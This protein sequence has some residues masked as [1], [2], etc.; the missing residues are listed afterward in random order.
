MAPL[1]RLGGLGGLLLSLLAS[2]TPCAGDGHAGGHC[3]DSCDSCDSD[4]SFLQAELRFATRATETRAPPAPLLKPIGRSFFSEDPANS[5]QWWLRYSSS[6]QLPP[7]KMMTVGLDQSSESAA[8]LVK[9][10]GEEV[11]KLYFL[12]VNDWKSP[13]NLTMKDFVQA[14]KLSWGSVMKREQLYSPWTDFHDGHIVETLRFDQLEMDMQPFQLYETGVVQRAYIPNTTWT[15]EWRTDP[16]SDRVFPSSAEYAELV[17]FKNPDKCRNHSN[18]EFP[19]RAYWKSTFPVLNASAA[20]EFALDVLHA[21]PLEKENPYPW[22]RQPGCIAVQWASLPQAAGEPFQLHFVEDFV[23][24]T[25]LHSIPEFLQYQQDFLQT[26]VSKGCINSFMLNNLILET[27]SLD[28]FARR[29]DELS[30]PYF[31]FAIEDRYALLFSFPGNEGVTLQ[32]QSP[33]LSYVAPR[34]VEFC[35]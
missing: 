3:H 22:P 26:D 5:A 2:G 18:D 29:L 7:E 15:M 14:A 4:I 35:K 12:N 19:E 20:T 33:H 8:V 16:D 24:D 11:E 21:K 6:E 34:P 32:L 1:G 10:K 30:V 31:V 25:V 27:E 9:S 13:S 17:M 23:Y 28:P